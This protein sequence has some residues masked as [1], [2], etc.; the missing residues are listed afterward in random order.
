MILSAEQN[1]KAFMPFNMAQPSLKVCWIAFLSI[2][3]VRLQQPSMARPQAG[4]ASI[5][6]VDPRSPSGIVIETGTLGKTD[7][8]L[9]GEA[10]GI[11]C[12]HGVLVRLSPEQEDVHFPPN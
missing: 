9:P 12:G 4:Y 7:P 10:M 5:Y 8:Y 11:F 6:W 1:R 2:S 3:F